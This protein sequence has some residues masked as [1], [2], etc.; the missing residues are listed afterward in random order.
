MS[1][2]FIA[3]K[4]GLRQIA[5]RLVER[6]GFGI[7]GGELYQN[8]MDTDATE[9][10]ITIEKLPNRPL[11]ELKVVDNDPNG[12]P[13]LTHAWTVFASSFK[14]LDP[15]KAGRFNLG[16]KMVLSF[17]REARIH[18][19][20][21][22]VEFGPEGRKDYTRRKREF[23]TEF[24]CLIDCTQERYDQ[25]IDYMRRIIV[26]PNLSLSVNGEI[27][28]SRQPIA[29]FSEKLPTEVAGE[30]GILRRTIR[31]TEIEIFEPLPS[32]IPSL[33]EMGIPVVE[34]G[35]RWHYNVKQKVPL[36]IDRDNVTPAFLRDLRVHV[37]NYMHQNI[38]EEDTTSEWVNV[39]TNDE[40]CSGQA[41]ETF[42]VKRYGEKSVAFD[43]TNPEANAEAVAHGFTLIPA[44]GLSSGQRKNLYDAG[45][46]LTSSMAFPLAGKGA[47]STDPDAS[48]VEVLDATEW[49]ESMTTLHEYTVGVAKRLLGKTVQVRFVRCK[50]FVGKPWI[51]CFGRGHAVSH[52]DYNV[53]KMGKE[54]FSKE[55]IQAVDD[56]ILHEL[57]H[58]F[59]SNHLSEKYYEACTKLGA[60]L[61]AA[62]L[63][64][65]DWFLKFLK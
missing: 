26:K 34:T 51:A 47:Y 45:T 65:P 7:I 56:L 12:F 61:K 23:G 4:N 25:L 49:T 62:V 21:G 6:R 43:P 54:W 20:K 42:R 37:L 8:V 11:A 32:E 40:H 13:D 35:D 30:D 5:E 33:M 46:L 60:R 41:A 10:I 48:P 3:N 55:N 50:S 38:T 39:A 28:Q 31:Q 36:N 52:F 44:R 2:W 16:E 22:M 24:W 59:E 1:D 14:K 9:C 29:V 19:T 27:I 58:E 18:T 17:C 63:V 53:Y 57:A 15:T 64:E